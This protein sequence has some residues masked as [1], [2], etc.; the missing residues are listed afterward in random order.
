MRRAIASKCRCENCNGT[1]RV[2]CDE[3]DGTG[4]AR[5]F[6]FTDIEAM[7]IDRWMSGYREL[8]ELKR[9][10]LTARQKAAQLKQMNPKYLADYERQ[11]EGAISEINQLAEEVIKKGEAEAKTGVPSYC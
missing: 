7:N 10:A 11:L 2:K 5:N 1:G 3:C 8:S 9:D 6:A 4:T